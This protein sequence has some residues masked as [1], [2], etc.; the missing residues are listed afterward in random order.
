MKDKVF[1]DTDIILDLFLDR[2]PYSRYAAD[3]FSLIEYNKI[4]GCVSPL[5]FSNLFYIVRKEKS[6]A[7]AKEILGKLNILTNI[8]TIDSKIIE[9][10]LVSSFKDFEDA[11]QYYTAKNNGIHTIITR[12]KEDYKVR[13]MIIVDAQEYLNI[14]KNKYF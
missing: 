14:F 11:V 8:L 3:L 2:R 1:I 10:S 12:N 4:T 6:V 5:I 7:K 9:L 13:D